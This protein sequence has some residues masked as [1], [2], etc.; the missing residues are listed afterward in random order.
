[1]EA[2][3][4]WLRLFPIDN[5]HQFYKLGSFVSPGQGLLKWVLFMDFMQ[6]QTQQRNPTK[7]GATKW[8]YPHSNSP[9]SSASGSQ[10]GHSPSIHCDLDPAISKSHPE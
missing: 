9:N 7:Y 3:I 8:F 1:M 2:G 6:N 5:L 10:E 4:Y